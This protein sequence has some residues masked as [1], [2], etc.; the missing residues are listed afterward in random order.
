MTAKTFHRSMERIRVS[1]VPNK[2]LDLGTWKD[3]LCEG[4]QDVHYSSSFVTQSP[5]AY[6]DCAKSR[7]MSVVEVTD[8][9]L[10]SAPKNAVRKA[11]QLRLSIDMLSHHCSAVPL[12]LAILSQLTMDGKC[13]S[14]VARLRRPQINILDTAPIPRTF[15]NKAIS[16]PGTTLIAWAQK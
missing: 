9:T 10:S 13:F 5:K 3:S 2:A 7:R 4:R 12:M 14:L 16:L 15:P 11:R 1:F 6:L 8:R